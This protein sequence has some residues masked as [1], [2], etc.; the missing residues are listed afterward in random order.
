MYSCPGARTSLKAKLMAAQRCA[1]AAGKLMRTSCTSRGVS[2]TEVR[3][4]DSKI[5]ADAFGPDSSPTRGDAMD[6][7]SKISIVKAPV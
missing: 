3:A 6:N 1:S 2:N 4:G 5:K 7:Y